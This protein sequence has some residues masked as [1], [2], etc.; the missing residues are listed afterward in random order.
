MSVLICFWA[1]GRNSRQ[2][3]AKIAPRIQVFQPKPV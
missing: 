3:L 1:K 2:T